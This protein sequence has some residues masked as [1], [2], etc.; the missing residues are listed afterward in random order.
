MFNLKNIHVIFDVS[1]LH[2]LII[3]CDLLVYYVFCKP[4]LQK[5]CL[6]SIQLSLSSM[7]KCGVIIK[8]I[9]HFTYCF[10]LNIFSSLLLPF[11]HI[12]ISLMEFDVYLVN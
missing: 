6:I 7:K 10:K 9:C 4:D 12:L 1:N 5:E 11:S 8:L 2:C 3:N